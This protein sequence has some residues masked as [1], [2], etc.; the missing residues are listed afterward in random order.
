MADNIVIVNVS[1]QQAPIPATLQRTGCIIS[2]GGTTLSALNS[3][4]LTQLSDLAALLVAPLTITGLS[5]LS[6]V[7]TITVASHPWTVGQK[8]WVNVVGAAPAAYNGKVLATVASSTTLT[9]SLMSNPG[10]ATTNGTV[11]AHS[12]YELTQMVTTF[13]AQGY[14]QGVYVLELGPGDVETGVG[15]LTTYLNDHPNAN[16]QPGDE[17]YFYHYLVPRSW[18]ADTDFLALIASYENTTAR[19]YFWVTTTLANYSAYST[20]MKSIFALVESPKLPINKQL[21]ISG[22]AYASNRVTLTVAASPIVAGD[23]FQV[24]GCTPAAYNGWHKAV[25]GTTATALVYEA[26][27][28]HGTMTVNGVVMPNYFANAAPPDTEFTLAS[29]MWVVLHYAPSDTNKVPPLAFSYVY[30]V[31]PFPVRGMGPVR[32]ALRAAYTNII[33]TGA[34]GGI[35]NA[36]VLWGRNRDGKPFNYW[37]STDWV[38]ITADVELANAIINGSNTPIN[39]LYYNQNGID[40]LEAVLARVVNRGVTFGLILFPAIQTGLTGPELT[41]ALSSNTFIGKSVVNAVPFIPYSQNNPSHYAQGQY[42]GLSASFVPL[43]GFA[44]ITVNLVV[45][46]FVV[47]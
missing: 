41:E 27:S 34:E 45:S 25:D 4:F 33:G 40:R 17:G 16:Y 15:A 18:D 5:W 21:A 6:N 38:A 3:A 44:Q 29:I 43:R 20:L 46:S 47:Q 39:P 36:I 13:F 42:D 14:Q 7:V 9:Y 8:V 32:T 28:D 24:S 22:A 30:G 11:V 37:Y 31:T 2:Q 1:Q 19:T 23:W 10:A 35:T 12:Y 26:A